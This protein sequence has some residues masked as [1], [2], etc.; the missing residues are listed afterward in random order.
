MNGKNVRCY[1]Y[2]YDGSI[3]VSPHFK[4]YEFRCKD[5]T[6]PIFISMTL[7]NVLEN[8]RKHFNKP[9]IINS[10]YRN[11]AK[12]GMS[13]G[14]KYSQHMYGLAAD[15]HIDGVSPSE[16][17]KYAETLMPHTGGIGIYDTFCHIDVRY[18]KSRWNG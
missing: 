6:D 13:G 17:A 16:I 14:A 8:I 18:E 11:P 15:I 7:V 4:V 3:K 9:V 2:K 10:A 12:N 1:S 5:N